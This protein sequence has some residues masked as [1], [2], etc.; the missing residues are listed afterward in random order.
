MLLAL[1][2][3]GLISFVRPTTLLGRVVE[4]FDGIPREIEGWTGYNVDPGESAELLPNSSVLIRDYINPE[5]RWANLA[6]V[7]GLDIADIHKPEYCF[8]SHGWVRVKERTTVLRPHT[9]KP[10]SIKMLLLKEKDGQL[11]VC[12]YWYAGLNGAKDT[13]T[14]QRFETWKGALLSREVQPSALIRVLVS[15]TE[16]Q[17]IAEKDTLSLAAALDPGIM[18]MVSRKPRIIKARR[19]VGE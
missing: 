5:A 16:S 15:V 13:L 12:A 18:K 8:E 2:F 6:I 1:A 4:K 14:A 11:T 9:G 17:S 19:M 10:H 7:Y 3:A